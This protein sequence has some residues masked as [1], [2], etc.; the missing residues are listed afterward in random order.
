MIYWSTRPVARRWFTL[1]LLL[2]PLACVGCGGGE[3]SVTTTG[4]EKRRQRA[5]G[6]KKKADMNGDSDVKKA[7]SP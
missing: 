1:S 4:G 3:G 2:A 6:L 5:E 7:S